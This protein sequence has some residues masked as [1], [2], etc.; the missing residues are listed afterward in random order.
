VTIDT[1][2]HTIWN[3]E[4]VYEFCTFFGARYPTYVGSRYAKFNLLKH[5]LLGHGLTRTELYEMLYS[6]D[7]DGGPICGQ[8]EINVHL[9]HLKKIMRKLDLVLRQARWSGEMRYRVVPK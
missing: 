3:G 4:R 7:P 1:Q 6:A 8:H 9:Q 5:L 2:N